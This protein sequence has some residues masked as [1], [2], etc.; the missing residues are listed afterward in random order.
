MIGARNLALLCL[1]LQ[2]LHLAIRFDGDALQDVVP[3]I[4]A[5]LIILLVAMATLE[6]GLL[7]LVAA[8]V[9]TAGAAVIIALN[10]ENVH[11]V[12]TALII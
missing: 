9:D 6:L 7:L 1:G 11:F 10:I 4:S 8:A 5:L 2:L 12:N 3:S